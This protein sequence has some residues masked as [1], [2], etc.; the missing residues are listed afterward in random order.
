MWGICLLPV[1]FLP[2]IESSMAGQVWSLHM[3]VM[4]IAD[5]KS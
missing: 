1:L 3:L 5:R 2:E 4:Y